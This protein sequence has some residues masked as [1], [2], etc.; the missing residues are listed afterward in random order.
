M[1]LVGGRTPHR[2]RH[3]LWLAGWWLLRAPSRQTADG[4][5]RCRWM[6][7]CSAR[8][9][10][11]ADRWAGA[12]KGRASVRPSLAV[13][14]SVD[15]SFCW[16][17]LVW[18]CPGSV[19]GCFWSLSLVVVGLLLFL[20]HGI[21]NWELELD[22]PAGS[23]R[24]AGGCPWRD[25]PAEYP[26]SQR[27]QWIAFSAFFEPGRVDCS[28]IHGFM[29]NS[30]NPSNPTQ[31]GN[32]I[33]SHVSCLPSPVP[34]QHQP[35]ALSDRHHRAAWPG[36][37][38]NG[39]GIME[40][41]VSASHRGLSRRFG[42]TAAHPPCASPRSVPAA[43][44]AKKATCP[45]SPAAFDLSTPDPPKTFTEQRRKKQSQRLG[46]RPALGRHHLHSSL[47]SPA[48]RHQTKP[49]QA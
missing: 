9:D 46:P 1:S 11:L 23:S 3:W 35:M 14:P 10:G 32:L 5:C 30:T 39:T 17:L 43:H 34:R 38:E 16:V 40:H 27:L 26:P 12:C 6:Q 28:R 29:G 18:V 4:G 19:P 31:P 24:D 48:G 21:G 20:P 42:A 41:P 2:P 22:T 45:Y 36:P 25:R 49:T 7:V 8:I 47:P 15:P 44:R 37:L 33:Q 13:V